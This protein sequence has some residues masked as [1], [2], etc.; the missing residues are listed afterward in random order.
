MTF[1]AQR[2]PRFSYEAPGT[3]P[4]PARIG[5][6]IRLLFGAGCAWL[7]GKLVLVGSAVVFERGLAFFPGLW[8]LIAIGA[9]VFPDVLNIGWGTAVPRRRVIGGLA[10][11]LAVAAAFGL[12]LSGDVFAPPLGAAVL[13]WLLYTFLHLGVSFLFA[14]AIRTPGC[15]MRSIPELWGRL[16]GS[17]AREHFCPG[18]MTPIDRWE[19]RRMADR[20]GA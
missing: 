14:A 20:A 1:Q 12:A 8:P 16:R 19:A 15:E 2:P 4:R 11:A 5:R 17:P 9:Y 7:V 3:L 18:I 6:N 10:A 13:A